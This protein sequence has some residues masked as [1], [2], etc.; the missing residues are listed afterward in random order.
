MGG[1]YFTRVSTATSAAAAPVRLRSL[2]VFRGLTIALMVLVNTPGSW[3]HVYA[4]L[5]HAEWHGMTLTDV[6]FPNFVFIVGASMTF[7]LGR[8]G[9]A[10]ER[11]PEQAARLGASGRKVARRVASIFAAGL[12]LNWFPFF[13]THVSDLRIYG[14][15]QRIALAYGLAAAVALL[16]PRRAWLPVAGA[17][18]L[19]YWAAMWGLAPGPDPYALEGNLKRA[20]DLATVGPDHMYG[21]F[22]VAFDPE[23]L[24][25][26]VSTAATML[27]GAYAGLLV[28]RPG[29]VFAKAGP[30]ANTAVRLALFGAALL[31]VGLHWHY[32][33]PINKP[34]WSSS[35]ACT[36]AGIASLVLAACVLLVDGTARRSGREWPAW[37]APFVHF[38]AN[39]LIVYVFSGVIVRVLLYVVRWEGR[40]GETVT[41]LGWLWTDVYSRWGLAP[42]LASLLFALTVVLVCYGFAWGLWRRQIFVK[43]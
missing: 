20:V 31:F 38:G 21:G 17:L 30:V 2:D 12:L 13:Q 16:V 4:P 34:L 9:W 3:S 32:L 27:F 33:F 8:V 10:G 28:R 23:G 24:I 25:G 1:A 29:R 6:V 40:G 14:V 35:Y 37:A 43:L 15:L 22:G 42:K 36:A 7:S 18:L 19:A 39:P 26:L 11:T 41:G 5:L